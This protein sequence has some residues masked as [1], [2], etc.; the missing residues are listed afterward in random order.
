[1]RTHMIEEEM[2]ADAATLKV[3]YT[4]LLAYMT[5]E[6]SNVYVMKHPL[7]HISPV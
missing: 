7:S 1:M 5:H 6:E 3:W 4:T 2:P